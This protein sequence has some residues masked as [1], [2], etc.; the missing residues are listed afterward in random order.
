MKQLLRISL[1]LSLLFLLGGWGSNGH[2]II[3][4]K[5]IFSFPAEMNQFRAWQSLLESHASDADNRKSTDPN[6]GPKHFI[7]IDNY[8]EFI[9]SGSISQNF[10]SIVALHGYSFVIDQ[11][12]LPW[13]ILITRDSL[14]QAFGRRDWN[15]AI[16]FAADLGHYIADAHMPLHI[17]RNYNGQFTGQTGIHS[18]YESTMINRYY[19]QIDYSSDTAF[20]VG[21]IPAFVFDFIYSSY[22]YVDSLLSA[23]LQAKTIAGNTSSDLYYQKMWEFTRNFTTKLF[24]EASFR[25]AAL[26]Y[27][28]WVNAGEPSLISAYEDE[29]VSIP[30][31]FQLEQNYPNPFNPS[32]TINYKVTSSGWIN[33]TVYDLHGQMI[34]QPVSR[35]HSPGEYSFVFK[36]TDLNSGIYF[37]SASA[38]ALKAVR[39]ML[40]VK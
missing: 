24:S 18:R 13:A 9:S 32:T 34:S 16:L 36:G 19:T 14:E 27:T 37:V 33:I 21:D 25:L 35:F 38:G 1:L 17:T 31:E 4:R 15:K 7:D 3:N 30:G 22:P 2:K 5:T 11:G 40:L 10:D 20:F 29:L 8:P 28:S 23:E 6:E 39:K 26:I 12:I